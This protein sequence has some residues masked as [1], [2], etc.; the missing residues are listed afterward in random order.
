MDQFSESLFPFLEKRPTFQDDAVLKREIDPSWLALLFSVL[1]CG[2]QFSSDP[3]KERDLRSKVFSRLQ[4]EHSTRL[5]IIFLSSV[6][7]C[8]YSMLL[9]PVS[10]GN[11][12]LQ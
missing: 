3:A 1:A 7:I 9:I 6:L 8:W 10:Q 4:F 5:N 2:V 11:K 12:L